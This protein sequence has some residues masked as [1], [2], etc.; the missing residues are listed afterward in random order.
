M[1]HTE[2]CV[3]R[4]SVA[5][6]VQDT[7]LLHRQPEGFD[8][9]ALEGRL[10]ASPD[11]PVV[12]R[13]YTSIHNI[14]VKTGGIR[15][16]ER[17][18]SASALTLAER[19]EIS[20]AIV[21]GASIRAIAAQLGRAP[22]TVS[23]ELKRNGGQEKYRAAQAE[24]DTWNRALRPKCCKLKENRILARIVTEKLRMLWSPE[25]IA[26][27][28][29]H[30]FPGAESL[31]VLHETIYRSLFIQARGALKKELLEHLRR[32]R[33]MAALVTTRRRRWVVGR[34]STQFLSANV[35]HRLKIE[36]CLVTGRVTWFSVAG[37][38]RS[39]RWLSARPDT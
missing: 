34:S 38:A 12:C 33:G 11:R 25:Q 28:L 7:K 16:P 22:S 39:R 20:R 6:E 21:A 24:S 37:T 14:L 18:R 13:P 26:G 1:Q 2:S 32:T 15:P 29:R 17:R 30:T 23:R 4:R 5:D 10:D 3:S 31:H 35:L 27:W 36:R 19:E 9:G 8:V